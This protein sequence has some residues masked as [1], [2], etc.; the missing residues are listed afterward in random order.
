DCNNE[1]YLKVKI[2]HGG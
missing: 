1:I 2:L